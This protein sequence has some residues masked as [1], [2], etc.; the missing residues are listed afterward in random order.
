M[1]SSGEVWRNQSP[2]ATAFDMGFRRRRRN[3]DGCFDFEKILIQEES[4]DRPDHHCPEL[5][6]IRFDAQP[7]PFIIHP[8]VIP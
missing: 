7:P 6:G 2:E 1:Q 4:A 3:S 8:P 5:Q